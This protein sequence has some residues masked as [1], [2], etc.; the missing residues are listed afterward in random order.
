[1][2]TLKKLLTL[3]PSTRLRKI[4][5]IFHQAAVEL[6]ANKEISSQKLSYLKDCSLIV[7][8]TFKELNIL[9]YNQN[10]YNKIK[11]NQNFEEISSLILKVLDEE[12]SDWDFTDS[13]LKL[14]KNERKLLPI[15]LVVDRI[16]SPF[17]I[18]SVFRIADSFGIQEILLIEGSASPLHPR[19]I[20]T[21][22]GTTD[23][24][25]WR[26]ITDE[27]IMELL[28][29]E[30]EKKSSILALELG[31]EPLKTFSFPSSGYA[32]IGNE[33]FGISSN[34]LKLASSRV[35]ISLAGT[36]GSLNVSN[37]TGIFLYEWFFSF[38]Q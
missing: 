32:I 13:F 35:S 7:E 3:K 24:V 37:A 34:L 4:S 14:D 5:I 6:H 17:N 36:K 21:S 20:K 22:R 26:F 2:I 11:E 15:T 23:T 31:G 9:D 30:R 8:Q 12:P 29:K 27:E 33:E 28:T 16:R 10:F 1:M 18:G 38:E 19:S 25:S